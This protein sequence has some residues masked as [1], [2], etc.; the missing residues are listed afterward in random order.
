MT[1]QYHATHT[2]DWRQQIR[3]NNRRSRWAITIFFL[4]YLSLGF[5]I[6]V[7]LRMEALLNSITVDNATTWQLAKIAMMQLTTLQ[8]MPGATLLF[9]AI[10][11]ISLLITFKLHNKIMLLGTNSHEVLPNS[12]VLEEK[13]LYNVVEEMKVAAGLQFMPRVYIIEA[14]YMN[15]FASGYNEKSAMVAITRGL[16]QKLNRAELQAVMA[17]ELSHV[18]HQDIKLT[19]IASVL[20][21]LI[22]IAIDIIF[23][24]MLYSDISSSNSSRGRRDNKAGGLLIIIM[25]LRIILPIITILLTL[26]LSRSR[27]LM[28]DA[29]AVELMRTGDPLGSALLKIH[30]DHTANQTTY[31]QSY[32]NTAHEDVR[33]YAY[34][35]SPSYAGISAA[36]A[37]NQL[38]STH[39][40]LE[41]RLKALGFT[42]KVD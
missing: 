42:K 26:Y 29:G 16:M 35:Y 21:N 19:L 5:A 36:S 18:R 25:I 23:R 8:V 38:F 6:D 7:V 12:T 37:L 39:P 33:L 27:E 34:L 9:G 14:D 4:I 13:Q 41:T 30:N 28:A 1:E 24:G 22:L 31:Q 32:N 40:S 3:Q 17:H 11:A 15:A 2:A 20:T 10:A